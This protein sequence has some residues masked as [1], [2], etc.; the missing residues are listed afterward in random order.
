[1]RK[2]SKIR[3]SDR[4]IRGLG[5]GEQDGWDLF[6]INWSENLSLSVDMNKK[7]CCSLP[8]GFVIDSHNSKPHNNF[9]IL[10]GCVR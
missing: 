4:E 5:L 10:A 2:L 3:K 9:P 1:M 7:S 6:V 8:L